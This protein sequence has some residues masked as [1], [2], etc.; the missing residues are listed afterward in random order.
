MQKIILLSIVL[1]F[2]LAGCVSQKK[3][4]N[5]SDQIRINQVGFYPESVKQFVLA[6]YEAKSFAVVD[7]D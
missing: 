6:D 1:G 2:F 7:E 4:K 3:E 5:P